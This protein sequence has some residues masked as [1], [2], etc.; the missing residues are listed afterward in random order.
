[1]SS[2]VGV[3]QLQVE[4]ESNGF[5]PS[6][7]ESLS[8]NLCWFLAV[9][10]ENYRIQDVVTPLKFNIA[11]ENRPSQKGHLFSN[12]MD[13][14]GFPQFLCHPQTEMQLGASDVEIVIGPTDH[15]VLPLSFEV[16]CVWGLAPAM[17]SVSEAFLGSE[18][19]WKSLKFEMTSWYKLFKCGGCVGG[20]KFVFF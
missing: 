2:W 19:L 8:L 15:A 7:K 3:K 10:R 6:E 18:K 16:G 20:G 4:C 11:I 1:M 14:M 5:S 13:C 17:M 12:H 9:V